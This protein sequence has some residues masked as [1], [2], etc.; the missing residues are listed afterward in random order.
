MAIAAPAPAKTY[1]QFVDDVDAA[2]D[3]D[4]ATIPLDEARAV[5]DPDLHAELVAHYERRWLRP[6]RV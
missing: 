5:L 2:T 4:T 1:A 3:A 6:R